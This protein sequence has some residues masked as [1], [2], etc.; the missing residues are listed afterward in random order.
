MV[1]KPDCHPDPPPVDNDMLPYKSVSD[2][3][4]RSSSPDHISDKIVLWS[5]PYS[6]WST[7]SWPSWVLWFCRLCCWSVWSFYWPPRRQL[8]T[9]LATWASRLDP[10]P[11]HPHPHPAAAVAAYC[12]RRMSTDTC[13]CVTCGACCGAEE[14]NDRA[15]TFKK[16]WILD[17]GNGGRSC[18]GSSLLTITVFSDYGIQ[19]FIWKYYGLLVT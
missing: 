2:Q 4:I 11:P 10:P 13:A 8:S 12:I 15:A 7:P 14:V 18:S 17:G 1:I 9:P 19:H 5:R 6:H 16:R 3:W